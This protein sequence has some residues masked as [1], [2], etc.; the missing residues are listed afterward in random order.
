MKKIIIT[1]A[2]GQLGW[3]LQQLALNNTS[4]EFLFYNSSEL[5]ITNTE[6]VEMLLRDEMPHYFI[7]CA[8]YTKVDKAETET[9][10]NYAV[11]ATA[12]GNIA[13]LCKEHNVTF[14]TVS[15]DYVFNGEGKNPYKTDEHTSP[16]NAYGAA[17]LKGEELAL[18]ANEGAIIIRTSWVYSTHGNNFVKTMLRLM[19]ER[20][21]IS[22][23]ADQQG[24]PTYAADLAKVILQIINEKENGNNHTG[25]YHYSNDGVITWHQFAETIK[26]LAELSCKVNAIATADYPTPAKRPAYSVMD[27]SKI[28][29]DFNIKG[30][31]WKESL[32]KCIEQLKIQSA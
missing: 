21:E 11:N 2:N 24:S 18:A 20:D 31:D 8:A 27:T 28:K 15:T 26:E 30:T 4:Y 5:D 17:K 12:V 6:Q 32:K 16:V 19:N 9:E 3:E 7:N 10:L 25:I 22:V 14:I 23:V 1:G 29:T 13:K